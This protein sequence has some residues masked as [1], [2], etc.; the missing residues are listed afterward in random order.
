MDRSIQQLQE[1][2]AKLSQEVFYGGEGEDSVEAIVYES[3]EGAGEISLEA[4]LSASGY[5]SVVSLEQLQL[6]M[7]EYEGGKCCYDAIMARLTNV[8][9][10]ML[11]TPDGDEIDRNC[12]QVGKLI[13]I[14]QFSDDAWIAI[15]PNRLIDEDNFSEEDMYSIE[16]DDT[17]NPEAIAFA[18]HLEEITTGFIGWE[19]EFWESHPSPNWLVITALRCQGLIDKV[20]ERTR[21]IYRFPVTNPKEQFF[22]HLYLCCSSDEEEEYPARLDMLEKL[23]CEQFSHFEEYYFGKSG[24]FALF[25]IGQVIGKSA[26]GG[27]ITNVAMT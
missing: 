5:L 24:T 11:H 27:L 2:L 7:N 16:L 12:C 17:S 13:L 23:V 6:A 10:F 1:T 15:T 25:L 14:G 26:K 18:S 3:S 9:G 4:L 8:Q 19:K 20:I 21:F 22:S